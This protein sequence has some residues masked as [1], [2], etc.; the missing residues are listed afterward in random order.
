[1]LIR[2]DDEDDIGTKRGNNALRYKHRQVAPVWSDICD[3]YAR[4]RSYKQL[5]SCKTDTPP[6]D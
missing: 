4:V 5:I 3:V 6:F 2:W 1:M